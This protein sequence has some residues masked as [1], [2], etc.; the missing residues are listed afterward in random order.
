MVGGAMCCGVLKTDLIVGVGAE[1]YAEVLAQP[2][3]R[4][5]DFTGK[6]AV[7][8]PSRSGSRAEALTDYAQKD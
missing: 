6:R 1:N 3:A 5:F 8:W 4:P 2:G 7:P